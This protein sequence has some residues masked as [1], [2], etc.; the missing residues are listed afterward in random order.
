MMAE[1]TQLIQKAE[2]LEDLAESISSR[3]AGTVRMGCFPTAVPHVVPEIMGRLK[4][5]Y[6]AITLEMRE[7]TISVMVEELLRGELDVALTYNV[8]L[9]GAIR[10]ETLFPVYQHVAVA[11]NDPIAD[12]Q[13]VSLESLS[14]KPMILLDIPVCKEYVLEAYRLA[15]VAP[16]ILFQTGSSSVV[17]NLVATGQG[18]SM[19]A[20]RPPTHSLSAPARL[21]FLRVSNEL[22][23][24]D[25]GIAVARDGKPSR[26]LEVFLDLLRSLAPGWTFH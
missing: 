1:I 22:P 5:R 24:M 12:N 14:S 10:F 26:T 15:G 18:Y 23:R 21:R 25:F 13:T 20:F 11:E 16:R 19:M 7:N 9:D 17:E 4:Q 3:I 6:P 2:Q 8:S